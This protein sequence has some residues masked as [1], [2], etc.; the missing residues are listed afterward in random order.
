MEKHF[1]A[2]I[3]TALVVSAGLSGCGSD[4]NTGKAA[5]PKSAGAK[6]VYL[7]PLGKVDKVFLSTIEESVEDFYG[8]RCETRE[9]KPL[10]K[11]LLAKSRTR[12]SGDSILK[13]FDGAENI[14]LLT[15]E[16]IVANHKERGIP[17]WG[18]IGLGYR[19]GNVCV[20]STH[21]LEGK[22]G[23]GKT[24]ERLRKVAVHEIG[25]NLGIDHC[26][27]DPECLMNDANGTV[28][29]IDRERMYICG[30]CKRSAGM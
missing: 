29:Q 26:N 2:G 19:P 13:R 20:V 14:L 25:H 4:A 27:S 28:A 6:T 17:E 3:L 24:I 22:A 12:Y 10:T 9:A 18:V 30:K 8:Y 23:R 16:D 15:E 11:D 21:R 7:Q 5:A 1:T